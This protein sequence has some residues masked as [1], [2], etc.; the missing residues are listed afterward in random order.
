M[1]LFKT[2]TL[3]LVGCTLMLLITPIRG[4][5]Q[6]IDFGNIID[7]SKGSESD[8]T[9]KAE[10]LFQTVID[11][12]DFSDLYLGRNYYST[13]CGLNTVSEVQKIELEKA[14]SFGVSKQKR[15]SQV[16]DF[17]IRTKA[18]IN[19][20]GQ[21][22]TNQGQTNLYRTLTTI[23]N[24]FDPEADVKHL[25]I[26]SDFCENSSAGNFNEYI[27]QPSSIM[28][29]YENIIKKF[30]QDHALPNLK[31]FRVVLIT[32]GTSDFHLWFSRFWQ[33]FLMSRGAQEV[34]VRAAL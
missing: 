13:L 14:S 18:E 34:N 19:Q 6:S 9:F 3:I 17:L 29:N 28:D 8:K 11:V 25:I 4:F 27:H 21:V 32:P 26:Y 12:Y 15:K 2:I 5:A 10:A 16:S 7:V 20:L 1:E 33:K 31:G 24:E 30:S 22:P 23:V